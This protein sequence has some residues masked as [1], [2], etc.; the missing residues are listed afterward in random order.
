MHMYH[1]LFQPQNKLLALLAPGVVN[2]YD[3]NATD[4][5]CLG[6]E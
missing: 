3:L 1:H 2:S 4:H 5:I 6:M